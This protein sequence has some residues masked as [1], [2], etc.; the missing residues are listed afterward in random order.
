MDFINQA[1]AQASD[2]FRSMTVGA[3]ITAGLLLAVVVISLAYLFNYQVNGGETYLLGG[4]HFSTSELTAMQAAFSEA[5]LGGY[6][7]EG[8]RIRIPRAQQAAYVA[9]LAEAK[10]LPMNWNDHLVRALDASNP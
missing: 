9:A 5:G 1:T 10:A 7:V 8:G 2:L 4:Q 3:R 6:E